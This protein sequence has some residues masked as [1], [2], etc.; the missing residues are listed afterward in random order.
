MRDAKG[1]EDL[2]RQ[3]ISHLKSTLFQLQEVVR[4]SER[5]EELMVRE[6]RV[7]RDEIEEMRRET[8]RLKYELFL[9]SR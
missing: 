3:Q 8:E 6:Q 1:D 9:S 7:L 2:Y 5:S 4:A